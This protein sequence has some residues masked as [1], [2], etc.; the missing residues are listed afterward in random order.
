MADQA[1]EK[2]CGTCRFIRAVHGGH[3]CHRWPPQ[4]FFIPASG[5]SGPQ[6]ISDWPPVMVVNDCGE[7]RTKDAGAG[8]VELVPD[9][10]TSF[11]PLL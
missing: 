5:L 11:R 7:W 10:V 1:P 3:Q 6:T 4:A 8:V 2:N 9:A